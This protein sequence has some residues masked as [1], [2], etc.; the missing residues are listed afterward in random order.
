MISEIHLTAYGE[1]NTV[2]FLRSKPLIIIHRRINRA[3]ALSEALVTPRTSTTNYRNGFTMGYPGCSGPLRW[4]IIPSWNCL[5][6][7]RQCRL[8]PSAQHLW[9]L[10]S[11]SSSVS[12]SR[13]HTE[14]ALPSRVDDDVIDDVTG[15]QVLVWSAET[16]SR[17]RQLSRHA[18]L[19]TYITHTHT[20][21]HTASTDKSPESS[22]NLKFLN[23]ISI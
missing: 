16:S 14:A 20:H 11:Q 22:L 13:A 12:Q 21:T 1:E 23:A 4:L 15:G 3:K 7:G 19:I 9:V 17:K 6:A 18:S 5:T 2:Y 10:T 8:H